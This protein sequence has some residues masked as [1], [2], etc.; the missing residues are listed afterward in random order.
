[1]VLANLIFVLWVKRY[2][3]IK[4]NTIK[5]TLFHSEQIGAAGAKSPQTSSYVPKCF[6]EFL[7]IFI[8]GT[9]QAQ[10]C[11]CSW[12]QFQLIKGM[13]AVSLVSLASW[14]FWLQEKLLKRVSATLYLGGIVSYAFSNPI[15]LALCSKVINFSWKHFNQWVLY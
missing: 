7:K 5:N 6:Q 10:R 3:S 4:C 14:F 1:M 15:M 8:C 13:L 12:E 2:V 9:V 11:T